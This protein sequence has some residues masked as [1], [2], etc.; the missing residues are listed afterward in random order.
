VPPRFFRR[1]LAGSSSGDL[2]LLDRQ[3]RDCT[4]VSYQPS[5]EKLKASSKYRHSQ[6]SAR[7]KKELLHFNERD[8]RLTIYPL[9]TLQGHREFLE[10]KYRQ[11]QSITLEGF[12]FE[13]PESADDVEGILEDL[14]SGFVK[15]Y[16]FGLG[17]LKNYRFLIDAIETLPAIRHIV[18]SKKQ[19]TQVSS[20]SY[21]L[22]YKEYDAIR[23]AI[24]RIT[25]KLQEQ[26]SEDKYILVHN[27]LLTRLDPDAHP[28][29]ARPYKKDT[30]FK[31][32]SSD[33]KKHISLSVA[34]QNAAIRLVEEN[35]REIAQKAPKQL[36]QLRKDIELVT[37]E[38]MIAKFEEMLAKAL[39]EARW[40][41][42]FNDNP[43]ILNLAFGFPVIKIQ[44]QAHVGGRTLSGSGETI[45]DFLVKNRISNNAALFEIKTPA[46]PVLNRKAYRDKL[47]AP[48][49]DLV[50]A[51]NQM[52]DQKNEFQKAVATLKESTRVYDLESY[53]VHGVLV[54]G[55]T[56][57][58]IDHQKSF[59]LFRGNS[60]DI[61]VLTF[62][63]LLG[64]LKL[65]YEFF[66]SNAPEAHRTF[67]LNSLETKVLR[68]EH[69]FH[70]LF[71][72]SE[73]RSGAYRVTTS[74]PLPGVNGKSVGSAI[75]KLAILKAGFERVRL[76]NPPY[77]IA[78][79]DS[80][81]HTVKVKTVDEFI[82]QAEKIIAEAD[83]V[84]AMQI[85]H[86]G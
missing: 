23:R 84:L 28:E 67:L 34:D 40:Q 60:K 12:G 51:I 62:D 61:T 9:N 49:S 54:I 15:D 83:A 26:G 78:F 74:K 45:T 50:G 46:T 16:G 7:P 39:P 75:G 30:I 24:N 63:E 68:L 53:S 38:V 29:Q 37:L 35:K 4:T 11:I 3:S 19:T 70:G 10:P 73:S 8:D 21:V 25:T 69:E 44:D 41:E 79:D 2:L 76:Q 6:N 56:P 20:D 85:R 18:I 17:L 14:P 13:M 52:L 48:S 1:R 27:S 33:D 32:I 81:E 31:L 72:Y 5:R 71:R 65:L 58:D 59:E 36:L 57:Q 82:P 77:P 66:V 55:T 86:K 42:L 43:F 47:Y 80:G 22:S 64:K